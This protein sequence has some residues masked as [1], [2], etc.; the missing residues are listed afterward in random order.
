MAEFTHNDLRSARE[1]R[2]IQ[3][4]RLANELGVS[5]DTVRRW[6]IGETQPTPDDVGNIERILDAP[7]LWH[8]WM[9]SNF[10]S[11]RERYTD[12]PVA[13]HLA[14]SVIRMKY[15][16]EDLIPYFKRLEKDAIDGHMD[17]DD[18]RREFPKEAHEA[19]AAIQQL[20]DIMKSE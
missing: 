4:W 6:E 20:L 2:K 8:R 1:A 11:Y 15:E 13:G 7:G 12:I 5:E 17:N 19:I 3:R 16:V 14:A 10:E 9:L 18:L